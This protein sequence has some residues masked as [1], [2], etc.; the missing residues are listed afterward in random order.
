[1]TSLNTFLSASSHPLENKLLLTCIRVVQDEDLSR[2]SRILAESDIDWDYVV[3]TAR[4]QRV[5]PLLYQTLKA[6]CPQLVPAVVM[7]KLHGFYMQ[8]AAC[9]IASGYGLVDVLNW[10]DGVGIE[11]I[12]FKGPTL[13]EF[14]F[15]DL[16]LR[17]FVD[18]DI[19][20][21]PHDVVKAFHVLAENGFFPHTL[22]TDSQINALVAGEYSL[23][24]SKGRAWTGSLN[25]IDLH[26]ELTGKFSHRD[27]D[28]DHLR[29][30]LYEAEFCGGRVRQMS[31]EDLLVYLCIHGSKECWG[32]L[33]F[34]CA[35]SEVIQTRPDLDWDYIFALARW[36]KC[37]R[38]LYLGLYLADVLLGTSLPENVAKR[39]SADVAVVEIADYVQS[40]LFPETQSSSTTWLPN[41]F[42][43]FHIK[44]NDSF[45]D[46][47]RYA[48]KSIFQPTRIEWQELS[49]PSSYHFLHYLYRP[50]HLVRNAIAAGSSKSKHS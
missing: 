37:Q 36:A 27:L 20:I 44:V 43:T 48:V 30:R 42:S 21:H 24:F 5:L 31:V 1:M 11:A 38:R 40:N 47:V 18:L 8:N 19:L 23:E 3:V 34:I 49:L 2:I 26:W 9:S 17:Q 25:Q 7:E 12:P 29:P 16:G 14:Y 41:Y 13:A 35:V 39:I 33:S 22:L 45:A 10:L 46:G 32:Q 28:L 15:G 4:R 6:A 50:L